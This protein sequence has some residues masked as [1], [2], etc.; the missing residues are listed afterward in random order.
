[1]SRRIELELT[2]SRPDGSWTWRAAGAR[3]PRGELDGSILPSGCKVGDVLRADADFDI[4]GITVLSVLPPKGSRPEP[5][6]IEIIGPQREFQP[7]TSTLTGKSDRGDRRG[8]RRD[9]PDRPDR[10]SRPDQR[11]RRERP[12]RTERAERPSRPRREPPP[13]LPER[14]KPKKLRPARVHRDALVASLP[15]E[16]QAIA[17]QLC[18]GGVPSVRQALDEQNAAARA[19]GKPE[20]PTTTVLGL[21]EELAPKVRVAEWLDRAEAAVTDVDQIALR[22][23]R[24]VVTAAD[25]VARDETTRGL[26][27]TLR[28]ALERRTVTEQETWVADVKASIDAGRVVRALRL[29]S[30]PPQPSE[31]LPQE[32]VDRLAELAGAAL[33][34]DAPGDRWATVLDAVAYSPVRKTVVP[35]GAPAEPGDELLTMAR[36]HAGRVPA[37]A[38]LFGIEPPPP[39][40]AK[41]AP[42]PPKPKPKPEKA[43]HPPLP[44]GPGGLRRIPPPPVRKIP[45]P[46]VAPPVASPDA[47]TPAMG[48]EG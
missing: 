1:M 11:E 13:P 23:L 22:D 2:S 6:R 16:Q 43:S 34:A 21:A 48:D 10:P 42:R 24:A 12:A 3:E 19:E 4:D 45:P 37:A 29:S 14:P 27:S 46:P 39:P 36:K 31:T 25:D 15:P 5:E 9:R 7:V 41:R 30:R 8:P 35:A 17:E 44:P 40:A 26:A 33:A 20:V 18:K 38:K 32:L 28:E 47:P